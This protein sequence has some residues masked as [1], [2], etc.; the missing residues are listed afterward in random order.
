[1]ATHNIDPT[2]G[3][4]AMAEAWALAVFRTT[5]LGVLAFAAAVIL[6]VLSH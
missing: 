3:P 2:A 4:D 6:Y 1:M 5:C